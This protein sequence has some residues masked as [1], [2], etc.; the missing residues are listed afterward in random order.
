MLNSD[1]IAFEPGAITRIGQVPHP[2]AA[3]H[4]LASTPL[5]SKK[6][7]FVIAP[8]VM[9]QRIVVEGLRAFG[10]ESVKAWDGSI[11][12][13]W[14]HGGA[15]FTVIDE[16]LLDEARLPSPT[17]LSRAVRRVEPDLQWSL[18]RAQEWLTKYGYE[19]DK[20]ANQPGAWALRGDVLDVY[21]DQ[22]LRIEFFGETVDR[23][24]SFDIKTGARGE[25]LDHVD[26]V[27]IEMKGRSTLFDHLPPE[28]V[29]VQMHGTPM[30]IPQAQILLEP[31]LGEDVHPAGYKESKS[32]HL[33][34]ADVVADLS[35]ASEALVLTSQHEKVQG[36]LDEAASG[37]TGVDVSLREFGLPSA[38]F[39]RDDLLVLT[40]TA[41]GFAEEEQAQ[42]AARVQ[43]A[44]IQTLK[45]GDHVVH[46]HHGIA[47]YGGTS[48]M[49]INEMDREFFVLEYAEGDKIYVPVEL[50][51]RIDKYIG[52]E[53]PKLHR[54]S[55][56]SWAEAVTRVK[57]NT[58]ELARELLDLYARRSMSKA[59]QFVEEPEEKQLD[60]AC[61]FTLTT[62]Q[63][64]ALKDV[65]T[66]MSQERPMD[67]LLC[68]DVGFGKT[69]VALRAAYRAVLNGYQVAL[70]APTTILAQQHFDTFVER[71][72][73]MGVVVASL[74]RFRTPK[75]QRDAV[76]RLATGQIDIV[77][78]THRLLS[79]DIHFKKLGLI[80]VDE[81][82]RFGVRAKEWLTKLR[83]S[84]HM[85]TMT[86]T[87]IPRTLHLSVAGVRDISTILTPPNERRAVQTTIQP[88]NTD[89]IVESVGREMERN[90][91]TYYVY[92]R[93]QTIQKKMRELQ[94]LLPKARI[95]I[96]HGQMP[97]KELSEVMHAFDTGE[98]DVLLATT[99]VENGLDIPTANTLIVENA[100][101]FG[102]AELYQLKGRV[103]RAARQGYAYFFFTESNPDGDVRRRFIALQEADELGAGF[104]LAMKDME[105][106][107]IG[108]MLG[109]EQHGHAVK[110]GMNL[111]VRLLNQAV[112]EMKGDDLEPERDVPIDL[113]MEARIPE[114]LLPDAGERVLLYQRL[115]NIREV[116]SLLQQRAR[117][118]KEERFKAHGAMDPALAGLFDLLEIKLLAAHS[119]LLS[120]DT[121][122]PN[123]MN[124]LSSAEI[125]ITS[126]R[127]IP[128]LDA[129][130]DFVS[131]GGTEGRRVRIGIDVLGDNWVERLKHTIR[132]ISAEAR[133]AAA[134][135]MEIEQ[136]P[137]T[138]E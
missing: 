118:T 58:L 17:S 43:Q 125:T 67:R 39:T 98:L 19:R 25:A 84:A 135:Q 34:F 59:H 55:N 96:A 87:P 2:L 105:I 76:E 29:V 20:T 51:D 86:A 78:G 119:P 13:V 75:E 46:T 83:R 38:G 70:L 16:T 124:G 11:A 94:A 54:L 42:Q 71:L 7:V 138:Q 26:L 65:F 117:Y 18:A 99:I 57:E 106:R 122:Y 68:G 73:D 14:G 45:P 97:P 123:N 53:T 21:T 35:G 109:K 62:D 74:S 121:T 115:A 120:I 93:V 133:L 10:A 101:M 28:A 132:L 41:I 31:F 131:G 37:G 85:L 40:D 23:I 1:V 77:V 107:G 91:Q 103:G 36:F 9:Q 80:V 95:G 89:L 111:Y 44:M 116:S 72:K 48:V 127:S 61:Q 81:E 129:E 24:S 134:E 128:T 104:E 66:D 114:N 63:V 88:M 8:T 52:V 6:A 4:L 60:E 113:P 30:E 100:S 126:E 27:P 5:L 15:E 112:R 12:G 49:H 3:A 137:I 92:N 108:N 90:G 102:L 22:P 130:W 47:K 33:R 79:K 32:Y 56:A 50:A 110:I 136:E 64:Q 69:E 82:Q